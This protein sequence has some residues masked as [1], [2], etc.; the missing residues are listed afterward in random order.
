V[1]T[2]A[3]STEQNRGEQEQLS[4]IGRKKIERDWKGT[5]VQSDGSESRGQL[6][7]KK[8]K[9]CAPLEKSG[10]RV[11]GEKFIERKEQTIFNYLRIHVA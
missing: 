1:E 2:G 7:K 11:V 10:K 9:S 8:R 3:A 6:A 5:Q 4:A